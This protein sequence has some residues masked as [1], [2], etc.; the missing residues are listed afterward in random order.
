MLHEADTLEAEV[1]N[2]ETLMRERGITPT[3]QRLE[4]AAVLLMRPQHLSADQVM[5]LANRKGAAVSKATVYN[6]LK[7]FAAKGLVREVI[8]DPTKV[9]YDS[10][11]APHYHI[12]NVDTGTLVDV[13]S[14]L[15][16][17]Q[18]LPELPNGTVADGIDVIVRVRNKPLAAV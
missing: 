2:L 18:G 5:A 1:E 10:T 3:Q 11:T 17:V 6:T 7:L 16:A 4:I 9:F 15:V 13:N 8:V 14:D 12:Y